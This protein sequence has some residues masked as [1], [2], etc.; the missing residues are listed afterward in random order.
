MPTDDL[1]PDW[2]VQVSVHF[3]PADYQGRGVHLLNVRA[4]TFGDLG[5][6][7]DACPD[8]LA[9]KVASLVGTVDTYSTITKGTGGTVEV[10]H[11]AGAAQAAASSGY[12]HCAHGERKFFRKPDWDAFFCPLPKNAK[13]KCDPIFRNDNNEGDYNW[14]AKAA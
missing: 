10:V 9:D 3:G 6:L 11:D 12:P 2:R 5:E 7:L 13:G 4:D 1:I 14:P 8:D